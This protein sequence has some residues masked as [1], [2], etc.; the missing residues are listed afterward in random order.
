MAVAATAPND[1]GAQWGPRYLL[2]LIPA[3]AALAWYRA[4]QLLRALRRPERA[5]AAILAA[6]LL[7]LSVGLQL[8]SLSVLEHSLARSKRLQEATAAAGHAVI[9]TDVWWTPQILARLYFERRVFLLHPPHELD[10][11]LARLAAKGVSSFT[12][13]ATRDELRDLDRLRA[14]GADCHQTAELAGP[15]RVLDCRATPDS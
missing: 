2:P 14:A 5:A 1:G 13:V 9:L 10:A 12:F 3:A 6:V 8:H 15:A 4:E 7:A 11:F